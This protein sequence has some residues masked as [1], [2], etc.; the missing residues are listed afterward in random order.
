M[1][2]APLISC[3]MVTR[4]RGFAV[5]FAIEAY[6]RQ[7]Y[8]NRE[9]VVVCDHPESG[10]A[11]RIAALGDPSIR[12]VEAGPAPLGSLRNASV[13]ASRGDLLCQWDDD[14]LHHPRRLEWQAAALANAGT[15]ALFLHRWLLWWPARRRLALSGWRAWEGSMLIRRE[16][17][18]PYPALP[19]GED[20]RAVGELM[21]RNQL[22]LLDEPLAYCY[23][24]HGGNTFDAGHF[25]M[26]LDNASRQVDAADY[27]AT[28]DWL[29]TQLP[30]RAY[31]DALAAAT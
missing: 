10:L 3:L 9:L 13:A 24:F 11:E 7:T 23:I 31:A 14:D 8:P 22:A 28:L 21:S 6:Q 1:A 29:A 19:R 30:M 27:E 26:L 20:T 16:A 5:R 12:Y 15:V 18:P 2:T 25:S 17:L 4:G